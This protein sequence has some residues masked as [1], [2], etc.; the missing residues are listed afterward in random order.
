MTSKEKLGPQMGLLVFFIQPLQPAAARRARHISAR[1]ENDL[2]GCEKKILKMLI[3]VFVFLSLV[4]V[5]N[6]AYA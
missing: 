2:W 5:Y 1:V 6:V 4:F 3:S